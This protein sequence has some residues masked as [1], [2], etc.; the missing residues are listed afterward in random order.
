MKR[1]TLKREGSKLLSALKRE[2]AAGA[3]QAAWH[4]HFWRRE[5]YATRIT[6]IWRGVC[7]RRRAVERRATV[8]QQRFAA[9]VQAMWRGRRGR[10]M[11]AK[12]KEDQAVQKCARKLQ[13]IFRGMKAR[14]LA[15]ARLQRMRWRRPV[16]DNLKMVRAGGA[17][18][19]RA[20][21]RRLS[22]LFHAVSITGHLSVQQFVG[23]LRRVIGCARARGAAAWR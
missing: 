6:A 7:G 10:E 16:A 23:S 3:I 14:R 2:R 22:Q 18:G 21:T 17:R 12:A 9:T 1:V 11:F 20:C 15:A 8:N 4:K 19:V 13:S 5:G